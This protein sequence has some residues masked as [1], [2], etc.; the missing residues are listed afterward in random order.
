[1]RIIC[2]GVSLDSII[3]EQYHLARKANISILE[4]NLMPEYEREAYVNLL[5]K[6][7]KDE[8]NAMKSK[9]KK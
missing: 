9:D 4:S 6:D 2:D 1:M 8:V 7:L 5:L 3:R